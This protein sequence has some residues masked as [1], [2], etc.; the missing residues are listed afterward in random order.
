ME[1]N[2]NNL[3]W[4]FAFLFL[5]GGNGFGGLF[6]NRGGV[7]MGPAP[8]TLDDVNEVVNNQSI[9]QQ[10]SAL[11]IATQ[12]NNYETAKMFQDQN[13]LMQSQ[14]NTNLINIIQGF[15]SITQQMM[16]QNAN[17]GQ[18]IDAL[19]FKM[20]TCC[21]D[22]KT[23]MLQDRLTDKTAEAVA[24]QNKLDNRDQTS[25]LLNQLG[26]FVAWTG[27]GTQGGTAVAGG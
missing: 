16:A 23:Q 8:A 27:S 22:I 11:G 19:G 24:L 3:L 6:G 25:T 14:N 15:N 18:K 21:C 13:L 12:N 7:P 17:L 4:F 9:Q 1:L 10:L 2:G 20:E 5:M 26:R